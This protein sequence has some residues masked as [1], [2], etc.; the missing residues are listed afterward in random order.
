[1][2][3][4]DKVVPFPGSSHQIIARLREIVAESA[5]HAILADG[6][7]SPDAELLDLCSK[8][9]YLLSRAEK[10]KAEAHLQKGGY[11]QYT[12]KMRAEDDRS[13]GDYWSL[14]RQA[15]PLMRAIA[16]IPAMT[17]AG[18]YAKA[19]I[20]KG[21]KGG[22]AGLAKTLAE[23]LVACRELRETLWSARSEVA[24]Q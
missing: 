1:M 19:L 17:P 6:P 12:D 13:M 10:A 16:K 18:I 4:G 15:T 9:L 2:S 7:V 24:E 11:E 5:D 3:G 8:A 14:N 20:V 21:S 23:D 22:A